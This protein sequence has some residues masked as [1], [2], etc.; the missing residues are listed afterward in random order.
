[1]ALERLTNLVLIVGIVNV[2]SLALVVVLAFYNAYTYRVL[3]RLAVL[4][5]LNDEERVEGRN[6]ERPASKRGRHAAPDARTVR[7]DSH[8]VPDAGGVEWTGP[9]VPYVP[10]DR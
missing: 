5:V 3:R 7:Y 8:H 6:V 10:E 1:M 9:V 4:L 2:L